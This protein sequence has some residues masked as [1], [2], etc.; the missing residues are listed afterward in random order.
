MVLLSCETLDLLND[1]TESLLIKD[2]LVTVLPLLESTYSVS[3]KLKPISYSLGWKCVA[4]FTT[5]GNYGAY[6]WRTP[7]ILK[8]YETDGLYIASAI[9]G[10]TDYLAQFITKPLTLNK[11]SRVRVSQF[12]NNGVY[13]FAVIINGINVYSTT[14]QNPKAFQNVKVFVADVWH[15]P[16][17]GFIKDFKIT[18]GIQVN[19]MSPTWVYTQ[20]TGTVLQTETYQFVCS[21]L[22]LRQQ[23]LCYQQEISTGIVT[24]LPIQVMD[25]IGYDPI[26]TIIYGRTLRNNFIEMNLNKRKSM[27][28]SIEKCSQIKACNPLLGS[29]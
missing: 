1:H 11:W 6:G 3:F 21:L 18:N 17:D 14:N 19:I 13:T 2:N 20:P 4:H 28:M 23:S 8:G 25:V 27:V 24:F 12:Q 22:L 9:N 15:D 26:T 29:K 16:L 10:S 5:G 7:A